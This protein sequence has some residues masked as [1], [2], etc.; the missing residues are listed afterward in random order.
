V[1][2]IARCLAVVICIFAWIG[3]SNHCALAAIAAKAQTV[4]GGCPFHSK[5]AKPQPQSGGAECCKVLR[6]VTTTPAKN[7]A[8]AIVDLVHTD[9]S[10]TELVVFAPPKIS[11]SQATL[12]TGPPGK[13]SF[14]ELI[15]SVRAHAPPFFA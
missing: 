8:P 3:I 11:F 15:G 6:A 12:D 2:A 7:S 1:K 14:V 10:F 9:V 13:T 5:P 4:P